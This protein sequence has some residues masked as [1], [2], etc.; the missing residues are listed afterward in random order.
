MFY[1]GCGGLVISGLC[2]IFDE[3]DRFFTPQIT[4]IALSTIGICLGVGVIGLFGFFCTTRSLTMIPP[5]TVAT[6]R[7]SQIFIAF[8]AQVLWIQNTA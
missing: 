3:N 2:Q 5:S 4:E 1:I 6:L 8:I 7:T